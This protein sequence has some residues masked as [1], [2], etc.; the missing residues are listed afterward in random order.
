LCYTNPYKRDE[1]R[2]APPG[3]LIGMADNFANQVQMQEQQQRHQPE[4]NIPSI[5]VETE[6][7]LS[8]KVWLFPNF[9]V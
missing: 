6:C 7:T 9:L 2:A 1:I 5:L 8:R 4:I 3:Y